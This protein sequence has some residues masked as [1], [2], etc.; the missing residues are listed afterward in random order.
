MPCRPFLAASSSCCISG[1]LKKS[2]WRAH[3]HRWLFVR[4]EESI[5]PVIPWPSV[6]PYVPAVRP[7][8]ERRNNRRHAHPSAVVDIKPCSNLRCIRLATLCG[9]V[10]KSCSDAANL[11]VSKQL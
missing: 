7:S 8:P 9:L 11:P 5:D 6:R 3:A 4:V 1:P 10:S 2:P